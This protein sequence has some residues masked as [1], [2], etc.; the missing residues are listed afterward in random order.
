MVTDV[1][2]CVNEEIGLLTAAYKA[3]GRESERERARL[4]S[5]D[6][7]RLYGVLQIMWW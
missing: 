7:I 3:S 2:L 4:G 5:I 1:C 6:V